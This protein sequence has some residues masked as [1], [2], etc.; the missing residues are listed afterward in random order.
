MTKPLYREVLR[1]IEAPVL[2]LDNNSVHIGK[3]RYELSAFSDHP[4]MIA[5][6]KVLE[7]DSLAPLSDISF[8]VRTGSEDNNSFQ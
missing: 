5:I 2:T 4:A 6:Q 7:S 8:Y 1:T 3:L